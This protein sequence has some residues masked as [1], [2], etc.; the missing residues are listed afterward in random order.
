MDAWSLL[1]PRSVFRPKQPARCQP[2]SALGPARCSRHS[3]SVRVGRVGAVQSLHV[4]LVS[5]P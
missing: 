2:G 5:S 4:F 3:G 1:L